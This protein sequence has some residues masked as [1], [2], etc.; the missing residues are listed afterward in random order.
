MTIWQKYILMKQILLFKIIF[1]S[2][3]IY[4]K[5]LIIKLIYL[6]LAIRITN[7]KKLDYAPQSQKN[8]HLQNDHWRT[9]VTKKIWQ[10]RLC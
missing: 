8:K 4:K 5:L 3:I 9:M 2:Y 1:Y 7:T 10:K 6:L